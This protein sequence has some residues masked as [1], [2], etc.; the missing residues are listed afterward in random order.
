MINPVSFSRSVVKT[1]SA[2]EAEPN[3]SNQ[4]E[5]NGVAELKNLLGEN[6]RTFTGTFSTRGMNDQIKSTLTWY[7]AREDHPTRSEFRLYFQTNPIMSQAS[8]GNTLIIGFDSD[9]HFYVELVR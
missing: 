3:R 9:E 7:D 6:R 1:L 8:G 4:H 5:L 2:V